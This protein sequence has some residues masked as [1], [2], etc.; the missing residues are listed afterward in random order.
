MTIIGQREF[1]ITKPIAF[2]STGAIFW[3]GCYNKLTNTEL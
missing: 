1:S 3:G 2:H